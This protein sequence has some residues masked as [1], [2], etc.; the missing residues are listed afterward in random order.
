MA[1]AILAVILPCAAFAQEVPV[2]Y[3]LTASTFHAGQA[4]VV[5]TVGLFDNATTCVWNAKQLGEQLDGPHHRL[6]QTGVPEWS[7]NRVVLQC[8]PSRVPD[9]CG[10]ARGDC[11][12]ND[13]KP[14]VVFLP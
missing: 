5:A 1:C 12:G 13:V 3:T 7:Q 11:R 8:L 2:V 10:V 9:T 4:P 6:P 14:V